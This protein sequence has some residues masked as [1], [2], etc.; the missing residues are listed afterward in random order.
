M[1]ERVFMDTSFW[2]LLRDNR[3]PGHSRVVEVARQLITGRVQLVV[4]EMV[5]AE[6]HAYFCRSTPRSLQILDDF[7]NNQAIHCEPW[8][9]IDQRTAFQ[10][11]RTHRDKAWSYCDA[12]SFA[13]MRRLGIRRAASAD[14]HF[15]QIG[16]FEVIC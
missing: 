2:I 1:R 15:R 5:L 11:L 4:T 10:L 14:Q 6:T 9:P 12:L 13:V 16:E 7:E 8:G 3:E